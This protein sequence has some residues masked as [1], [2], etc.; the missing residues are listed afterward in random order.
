VGWGNLVRSRLSHPPFVDALGWVW[1][2]C[3]KRVRSIWLRTH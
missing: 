3:L 1:L 2:I